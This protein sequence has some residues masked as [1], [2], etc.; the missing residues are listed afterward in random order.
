LARRVTVLLA[1]DHWRTVGKIIQCHVDQNIIVVTVANKYACWF[2][3][4]LLQTTRSFLRRFCKLGD[5]KTTLSLALVTGAMMATRAPAVADDNFFGKTI[6]VQVPSG[7]GSFYHAY[8]QLVQRN[9]SRFIA[10]KPNAVI[11]KR[12]GGGGA[13][14]VS[15]MYNVIPKN[16]TVTGMIVPGNITTPLARQVKFDSI[17]FE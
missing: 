17:K 2:H 13:K 3:D 4:V 8:C 10:G 15:Y 5:R 9:L 7:S 6:T 1:L 16:G 12:P 14:S 11:Q